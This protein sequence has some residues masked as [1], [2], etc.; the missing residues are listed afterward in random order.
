MNCSL[1][2]TF[3]KVSGKVYYRAEDLERLF[4]SN[5]TGGW[6]LDQ[7][8]SLF[9]ILNPHQEAFQ[10]PVIIADNLRYKKLVC[11]EGF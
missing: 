9:V 5:V 3:S 8:R 6:Q 2:R 1:S 4:N 11:H 10:N 7:L